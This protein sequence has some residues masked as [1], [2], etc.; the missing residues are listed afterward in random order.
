M[1]PSSDTTLQM[2]DDASGRRVRPSPEVVSSRMGDTGVLVH[3]QTNRIFEL[4]ATGV[5]VWE[6]LGEGRGLDDVE[7]VLQQEFEGDPGQLRAD[8]LSL[9]DA[10]E[11]ERLINDDRGQ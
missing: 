4:N 1:W 8:L 11:R 3:L 6:L 2:S 10:L 9:I 5:R 7:R